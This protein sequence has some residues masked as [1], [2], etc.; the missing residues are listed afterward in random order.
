MDPLLQIF[1]NNP[2]KLQLDEAKKQS[3]ALDMHI[4]GRNM[5]ESIETMEE[6]E[7]EQKKNVRQK[8]S[9]SNRDIFARLHGP[10]K[11]VFSAKGGST[12]INLPDSQLS[13]FNAFLA[14]IRKGTNLRKWVSTIA[15][16]AYHIDPNG[17]IFIEI[18]KDGKPYPTYKSTSDIFYYQLD[19][20]N[21][22]MVIFTVSNKEATQ[23]ALQSE[24]ASSLLDRLGKNKNNQTTKYYRVV[25]AV[26]DKIVEFDGKELT[27]I[28]ELSLPNMFMT[29]PA[30][31]VSDMYQFNSDLFISPDTEIIEVAN[32]YL[33]Q[34]SVFEI[35]KNLHMFPK[36]W[37]IQSV[38]PTCQGNKTLHGE[39]CRDCSGTGFQ[40]R[41]SVRD[42][43][44]IPAP[45]SVDGK[46]QIPTQFDGYTTPST[47]AW[48]LSV[49]DLDRL[50]SQMY[51]TKWGVLPE[52]KPQVK[53][54]QNDKTA[55]EVLHE[56]SAMVDA[57]Y[58]YSRWAESV[59]TFV[60]NMCASYMF[61]TT[62]KGCNVKY[63]DRYCIE[64]PDAIWD[65]YSKART[66]GASQA[67][68]DSLLVDY[69]ESKY[70]GSPI[71]LETAIKQM[72]VEPWVH[73][74]ALQVQALETTKLDKV[75]KV[76]FSEWAST[77]TDMDW[78][79]NSEEALRAALIDYVTPKLQTVIDE[80][81][82][83]TVSIK[84]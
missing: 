42:E 77:L 84:P 41:S 32:S 52:L 54:S 79:M 72:R 39:T 33:T 29:C 6:F 56:S 31:V 78:V 22:N 76:Y 3:E 46:I 44:I 8:Y 65:K 11:K 67:V 68:L 82:S 25:D 59:E 80:M 12:L 83:E 40:K 69:Y 57:L 81:V 34:N 58:A 5:R 50:Y 19:G 53:V 9:R 63:G 73:L 62:F 2:L 55:T 26:S 28:T 43:I 71:S 27:E 66:N 48:D 51:F 4:T 20:R 24:S 15:L 49:G 35:W 18:G 30:I 74:T 13:Q 61:P 17:L 70:A 21:V 38:C 64:S 16:D 47:E 36:H 37:R 1:L 45:E 7:T 14:N 60:I 23:Y 10:I 75:S